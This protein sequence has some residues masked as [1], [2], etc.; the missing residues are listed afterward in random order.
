LTLNYTSNQLADALTPVDDD[1]LVRN[2]ITVTRNTG[3]QARSV[4]DSGT[5]SVSLPP[6]G[7]GRYTDSL[8][9]S[10]GDDTQLADQANWRLHLGTVDEARYPS[11]SL[12]LRHSTFTSSVTTRQAAL[13]IDIGDRVVVAD[14]PSWLPPDDISILMFGSAEY[15]SGQEHTLKFNCV[16]ESG[17]RIGFANM[18]DDQDT[19]YG[20]V[21]TEGSTLN[22]NITTTATSISIATTSG[23]VWTTTAGDLPFDIVIGGEVMT[24]TA[25][26]GTTSPQTFTVTRSVNGVV[27]AQTTGADVRLAHPTYVSL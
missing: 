26:S 20:R 23:P 7:I 24:V 5:L 13:F 6:D 2:D 22:G 18:T 21:D 19:D 16:P 10:I 27:K 17:Y 9:L 8:T 25:V 12:N 1:S 15:I 14:P 11:I 3:A 4:L